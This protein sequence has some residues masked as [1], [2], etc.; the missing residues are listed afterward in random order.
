MTGFSKKDLDRYTVIPTPGVMTVSAFTDNIN[1][2]KV[3]GV[4]KKVYLGKRGILFGYFKSN[5]GKISGWLYMRENECWEKF[6]DQDMLVNLADKYRP[7]KKTGKPQDET[8]VL[9]VCKP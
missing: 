6:Y 7:D 5:E 8:V 4:S 9:K 3:V 1:E 2:R